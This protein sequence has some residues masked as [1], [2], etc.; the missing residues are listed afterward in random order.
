MPDP[1]YSVEIEF[2]PGSFTDITS[3]VDGF[4][5]AREIAGLFRDLT[6]SDC[7]LVLD[8]WNSDF[9]PDYPSSAY[10]GM[11]RP[12]IAIRVRATHSSSTYNLFTG[13]VDEWRVD[14]TMQAQR[15]ATIRAR[16]EIKNLR[17]RT[18]TSS[19]FTNF[20]VGSL[21]EDVLSLSGITSRGVDPIADETAFAWFRDENGSAA[22]SE[23][24][25]SGFFFGYVD[26]GGQFRV[27]NRYFDQ[28]GMVVGS[29]SEYFGLTYTKNDDDVL[30]DIAVE[31]AP[32]Q[33]Q[34]QVSTV[35]YIADPITIPASSHVGFWL[36]YLDPD[37]GEPAPAVDLVMPVNSSDYLTNTASTGGGTDRT[38]TT[39]VQ[40]SFFGQTAVNTVFNGS[41]DDVFLHKYQ[42]RGKS[43]QRRAR[44]AAT[45]EDG[46][47]QAVY[48]D[49]NFTLSND[50]IT[51]QAFAQ[52]YADFLRDRNAEPVPG[53]SMTLRNEFPAILGHELGDLVH[54]VNTET[55]VASRH[56]IS[57]IEHQ[58]NLTR[59][60]VHQLSIGLTRFRD[61]EVLYL[62][63]AEFGKI[64]ERRLGF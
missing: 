32:R 50:L 58:V 16:D 27:R 21:F 57:R 35:A 51:R 25:R 18:I 1:S 49:R 61:Q 47:S 46:S 9:S 8:N 22:V 64:D 30:N 45:A 23:I 54:V 59:G 29:Y 43:V 33:T 36:E 15:R 40:V 41:G 39:S 56:T 63:D 6:P 14:P 62:D 7:T 42:I 44:I 48:G 55:G 2:D 26:A 11:M 19:L 24:L 10:A 4:T 3:R 20:N 52:D 28:E 37:N 34:S 38:A 12:N 31:A 60:L 5:I 17:N 13:L 53:V